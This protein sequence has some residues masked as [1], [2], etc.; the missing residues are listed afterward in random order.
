M[1]FTLKIILSLLIVK[2]RSLTIFSAARQSFNTG[3]NRFGS[4]NDFSPTALAASECVSSD[5]VDESKSVHLQLNAKLSEIE[6]VV[7][8]EEEEDDE[9]GDTEDNANTIVIYEYFRPND[10][11]ILLAALGSRLESTALKYFAN[12]TFGRD[13]SALEGAVLMKVSRGP[14]LS[15]IYLIFNRRR[16]ALINGICFTPTADE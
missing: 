16:Y 7:V 2:S 1:S 15:V 12:E 11:T 8:E 9:K 10:S 5:A 3:L 4:V 13:S 6:V 14:C